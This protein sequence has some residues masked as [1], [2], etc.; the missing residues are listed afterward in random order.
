MVVSCGCV[1]FMIDAN[2]G[3]KTGNMKMPPAQSLG[4][5]MTVYCYLKGKEGTTYELAA[6]DIQL[7]RTLVI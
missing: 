6:I 7:I 4:M 2:T 5:M 3:E 1:S